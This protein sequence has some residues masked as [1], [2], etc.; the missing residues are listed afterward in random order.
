MLSRVTW[1]RVL[2]PREESSGAATCSSAPDL[3][4]LPRW[5]PAL[6]RG[7]DLTSLRGELRCCHVPHDPQQVMYHRNKKGLAIPGTP[8][9]SRVTKA[10]GRVLPRRL[11]G[12]RIDRYSSVQ[13]CSVDAANHY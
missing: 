3:A 11:Q 12:V 2:P 4:S 1:P 9:G 8:L 10:H 13:Q 5:A 6:P 7:L